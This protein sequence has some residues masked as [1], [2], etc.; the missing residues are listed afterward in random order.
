MQRFVAGSLR[1]PLAAAGSTTA[2]RSC[3]D[4]M[5]IMLVQQR[6]Q[7]SELIGAESDAR[8]V[9][10]QFRSLQQKFGVVR[11]AFWR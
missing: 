9:R 11:C 6:Q 10:T 4:I 1:D 8:Q 2:V 5:R 3:F 7:I